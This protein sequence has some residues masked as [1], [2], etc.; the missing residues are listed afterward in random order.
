MRALFPTILL[1]SLAVSAPSLAEGDPVRGKK[2]FNKCKAC[3]AVKAGK[4]KIGPSLY[5]VIGRKAGTAAGFKKYRGLK[6]A[7]WT[8]TEQNLDQ[9][10]TNPKK[11][12]KKKSNKRS[13]MV[14]KLKKK[15]DRD[16]VIAYLKSL[17]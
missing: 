10:L 9:Y 11:F 3:H 8:W 13:S 7:D 12:V 4:H 5:E 17:P 1:A 15:T 6:G 16:A 14:L 2:I